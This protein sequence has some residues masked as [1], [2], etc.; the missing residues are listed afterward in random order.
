MVHGPSFLIVFA[1]A[2]RGAGRRSR[3]SAKV[4]LG[5]AR[6]GELRTLEEPDLS[7]LDLTSLP[8][9]I[10][11]LSELRVLNSSSNAFAALT[12]GSAICVTRV[13][14]LRRLVLAMT[15]LES[16]PDDVTRPSTL[17]ELVSRRLARTGAGAAQPRRTATAPAR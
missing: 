17:E 3:A 5:T 8:D 12:A 2:G 11:D 6:I 1:S 9:E 4:T 10:G 15:P 7:S 16:I 14:K 13:P